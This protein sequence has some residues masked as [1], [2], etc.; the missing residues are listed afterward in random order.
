MLIDAVDWIGESLTP[1]YFIFCEL[2]AI[3]SH[4]SFMGSRLV[5]FDYIKKV[6]LACRFFKFFRGHNRYILD[7]GMFM[8]LDEVLSVLNNLFVE[9]IQ[10][11]FTI[12]KL[13]MSW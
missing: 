6:T 8:R 10:Q 5:I 7:E 3:F 1:F 2:A 4:F 13:L 9:L 12:S 11:S